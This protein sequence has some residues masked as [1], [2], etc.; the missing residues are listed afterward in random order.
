M[1]GFQSFIFLGAGGLAMCRTEPWAPVMLS[2]TGAS[3][4]ADNAKSSLLTMQTHSA[5]ESAQI[6]IPGKKSILP[7]GREVN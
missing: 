3:E 1:T 5:A 4:R 7:N 6:P 2:S